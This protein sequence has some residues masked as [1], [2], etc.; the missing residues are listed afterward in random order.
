MEST[1]QNHPAASTQHTSPSS[2]QKRWET[3]PTSC[4]NFTAAVDDANEIRS[5]FCTDPKCSECDPKDALHAS[6]FNKSGVLLSDERVDCSGLERHLEDIG[7]LGS[8]ALSENAPQ[9]R[10]YFP[11]NATTEGCMKT[12][13]MRRLMSHYHTP[14]D[15]ALTCAAE[16]LNLGF[17]AF[18]EVVDRGPNAP[19][20]RVLQCGLK[21]AVQLTSNDL[22]CDLDFFSPRMRLNQTKKAERSHTA[23]QDPVLCFT[24]DFAS[25]QCAVWSTEHGTIFRALQQACRDAAAMYLNDDPFVLFVVFLKCVLNATRR[26]A[27]RWREKIY[28]MSRIL[29]N[30]KLTKQNCSDLLEQFTKD[31]LAYARITDTMEAIVQDINEILRQHRSLVKAQRIPSNIA[32]TVNR[33]LETQKATASQLIMIFRGCQEANQ[34]YIDIILGYSQLKNS[35]ATEALAV[36]A[37]RDTQT[38]KTITY[39][40]LIYLPSTFVSTVFSMGMFD[41]D[42]DVGRT[43]Q[44]TIT[45]HGW[46]F[47]AVALPLTLVTIALAY[48]WMRIKGT[49]SHAAPTDSEATPGGSKSESPYRV[50]VRKGKDGAPKEMP[51]SEVPKEH[52]ARILAALNQRSGT[53]A[54]TKAENGHSAELA[55]RIGRRWRGADGV[56]HQDDIPMEGAPREEFNP[57]RAEI[58]RLLAADSPAQ[59]GSRA[60][61]SRILRWRRTPGDLEAK[62]VPR[63]RPLVETWA[64]SS[65]PK[66]EIARRLIELNVVSVLLDAGAGPTWSYTS[67]GTPKAYSRSEGLAVA[68]LD[69]YKA[70]FFSGKE[71]DDVG[72]VDADGLARAG[73]TT[74]GRAMQVGVD[75]QMDGLAGRAAL[76]SNLG[77]A[78]QDSKELFG[79]DARAGNLVDFLATQLKDGHVHVFVL[80]AALMDGLVRVWPATRTK[81]GGV[82]LGN[83]WPCPALVTH[84]ADPSNGEDLV[85]FHKLTQWLAYSLV[86]P[87]ER[88]L[89]WKVDGLD[90]MTR[91]PE[92]GNGTVRP[93]AHTAIFS[94]DNAQGGLFVEFGVP[95]N[96]GPQLT[97]EQTL[98]YSQ[99]KNAYA[100]EALAVDANRDTQTMKTITYVTLLFLPAT[101]VSSVFSMGIFDF[102]SDMASDGHIGI[103]KH[104]WV[105][106]AVALPLTLVT[107]AFAYLWMRI[108]G[109]VLNASPPDGGTDAERDSSSP[110]RIIQQRGQDG[111]RK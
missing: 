9:Y 33:N 63:L 3:W 1:P 56:Q 51:L 11:S 75:N 38:M 87:L 52:L 96:L 22:K 69:M 92:Y 34:S 44:I 68:S 2:T 8:Y 55:T 90:D 49:T 12:P 80:W 107:I 95:V 31:R 98:E 53:G 23:I 29:I 48:L 111:P 100:T 46:V 104:G 15:I 66:L 89:G 54:A 103:S 35:Y 19:P 106:L 30:P 74:A 71:K 108:K 24:Y 57:L 13:Y 14:M 110:F 50:T 97:L 67:P 91:L 36:D 4:R 73:E 62:P 32:N 41:F 77:M 102:D 45:R 42:S 21:Y 83:V 58:E 37:K 27:M 65:T 72:R 6:V 26:T 25:K 81:F 101:F 18:T 79:A 28:D 78:L 60:W 16:R 105:F 85:P 61:Y 17:Q 76:L 10:L 39:V 43:G 40:T 84:G 5:G 59:R 94:T 64:S 93:L 20:A 70:G 47:L 7:E 88:V 86:E 99:L 109:T 82:S